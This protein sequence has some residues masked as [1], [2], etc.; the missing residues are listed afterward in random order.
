MRIFFNAITLLLIIDPLGNIPLFLTTL[1]HVQPD[2]RRKVLVRDVS[3]YG[4]V[5]T[6]K[7]K[8]KR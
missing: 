8:S 7:E 4:N 5:T 1:K 6:A 2:R 3:R